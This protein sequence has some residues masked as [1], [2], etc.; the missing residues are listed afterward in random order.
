MLRNINADFEN[1]RHESHDEHARLFCVFERARAIPIALN[2][3][4][5]TPASSVEEKRE[6]PR[7]TQVVP[8]WYVEGGSRF[9]EP[10]EAIISILFSR[11]MRTFVK[12][13]G[14][15]VDEWVPR[16]P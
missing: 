2:N 8:A 6:T 3:V 9:D 12:L 11:R 10:M 13:S 5:T 14:A 16:D 15:S 7:T 4:K 1:K